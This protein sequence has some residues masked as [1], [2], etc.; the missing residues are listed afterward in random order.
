MGSE[1]L[2]YFGKILK[3]HG[4]KGYLLASCEVPEFNRI[5]VPDVIF[6]EIE[7]DRIPFFPDYFEFLTETTLLLKFDDISSPEEGDPFQACALFI[8]SSHAPEKKGTSFYKEEILGFN[9]I[10]TLHG[11]IGTIDAVLEFPSQTLLRV[12]R[13]EKEILIPV[14]PELIK[15]IDRRKR[16]IRVSLPEGLINLN[17]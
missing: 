4:N 1:E 2:Y 16:L 17:Y 11:E 10:D 5:D 6:V 14:A 3:T 8:P 12:L 9:V 7:G 15:K 13:E